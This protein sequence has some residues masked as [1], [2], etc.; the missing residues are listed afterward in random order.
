VF[1]IAQ[2]PTFVAASMVFT[3]NNTAKDSYAVTKTLSTANLG[4]GDKNN[5]LKETRGA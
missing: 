4:S 1:A 3:K 2:T 5:A